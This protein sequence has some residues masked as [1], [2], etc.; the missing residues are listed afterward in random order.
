MVR[1]RAAVADHQ[2]THRHTENCRNLER[3]PSRAIRYLASPPLR[4]ARLI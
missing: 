2:M 1:L 3:W 4:L